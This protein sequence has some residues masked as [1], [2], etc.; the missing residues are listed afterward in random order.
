LAHDHAY[1]TTVAEYP[2]PFSVGDRIT[3][4][5][6]PADPS[7]ARI[8][9]F[10]S[11]WIIPTFLLGFGLGFM[12]IGGAAFNAARNTYGKEI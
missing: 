10:R 7:P 3:V 11:L 4:L 12:G 8:K 6:Q 2:A 9:S 1:R 5:F